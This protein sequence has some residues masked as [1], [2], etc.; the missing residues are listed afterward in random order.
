MCA[1]S[2]AINFWISIR[3]GKVMPVVVG[4]APIV[5]ELSAH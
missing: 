5:E 4:D 3:P 1:R 2:I